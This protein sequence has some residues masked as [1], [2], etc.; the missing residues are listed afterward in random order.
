M[1]VSP[2]FLVATIVSLSLWNL[3]NAYVGPRALS[4]GTSSIRLPHLSKENH[5]L[6]ISSKLSM[7][8]TSVPLY[9]P[10]GK[11]LKED[12]KRKAPVFKS[13]FTGKYTSIGV[14]IIKCSRVS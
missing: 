2:C 10:F 11:G 7:A 3:S 4:T 1:L 12:I 13:E 14:T 6:G 8:T 5:N 9:E